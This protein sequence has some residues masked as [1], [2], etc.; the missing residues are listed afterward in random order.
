MHITR[1]MYSVGTEGKES[2][3]FT[4]YRGKERNKPFTHYSTY[5]FN[6]KLPLPSYKEYI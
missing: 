2:L 4:G 6:S 3:K 5:R 1:G